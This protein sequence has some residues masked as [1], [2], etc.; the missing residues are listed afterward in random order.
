MTSLNKVTLIGRL[1][2]DP[3]PHTFQD[4][5]QILGLS[6][7]TSRKWKDK[8]TQE[9]KEDTEWHSINITNQHWIDVGMRCVKGDLIYVEGA[10]KT[11][12][13][14]T[15]TGVEKSITEIVLAPFDGKLM[16]ISSKDPV[17]A[18]SDVELHDDVP[19][20]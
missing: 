4:G 7:A 9:W 5:N 12:K 13:S 17:A 20:F 15:K 1:G 2:Q 16:I 14:T 18:A 6:I 11:R 10:L 3:K 8:T 19:F